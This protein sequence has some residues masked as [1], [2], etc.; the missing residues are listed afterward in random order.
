MIKKSAVRWIVLGLL[1]QVGCG[2]GGDDPP[3]PSPDQETLDTSFLELEKPGTYTGE[4]TL[5][6]YD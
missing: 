6:K 1:I 2:G 4:G 5:K 3:P